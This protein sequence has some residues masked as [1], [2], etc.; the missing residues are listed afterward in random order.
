MALSTS[1]NKDRFIRAFMAVL[2]SRSAKVQIN[3]VFLV[4]LDF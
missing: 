1:V 3:S 2:V 4:P